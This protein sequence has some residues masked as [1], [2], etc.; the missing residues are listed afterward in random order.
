LPSVSDFDPVIE[1][2]RPP[3][4]RRL[5]IVN[6]ADLSSQP[7]TSKGIGMTALPSPE[8]YSGAISLERSP[9][10]TDLRSPA[11]A[12]EPTSFLLDQATRATRRGEHTLASSL[13]ARALEETPENLQA[14]LGL[15]S[16][17]LIQGKGQAAE[18]LALLALRIAPSSPDARLILAGLGMTQGRHEDAIQYL[19]AAK[20]DL[21]DLQ[22]RV[23]TLDAAVVA[24]LSRGLP[25]LT[26]WAGYLSAG[27][28]RN[29]LGVLSPDEGRDR[30][31]AR[32]VETR[33][34]RVADGEGFSE[35]FSTAQAIAR[36]KRSFTMVSLGA[37]YGK[38]MVN[39]VHMLRAVR[40][41]PYRLVAAE[42]DPNLGPM[43]T[44]HFRENGVGST[45]LTHI[46]AVVG[47]NNK[48]VLF[49][50]T[51]TRTGSNSALTSVD[52]IDAFVAAI[53]DGGHAERSIA[54]LLRDG[55]TGITITL[56][57][58]GVEA[59]L[60]LMSSVTLGDLLGPLDH[61]DYLDI[62]IQAAELD[63]LPPFIDLIARRVG[64][65]HLGTHGQGVHDA[66]A[67]MFRS[68][69]FR[70]EID[71]N[72]EATYETPG[73]SFRTQDGVLAV[74]NPK[75]D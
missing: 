30:R 18:E 65:I 35:W 16:S 67:G 17:Y 60:R 55:T 34:P 47:A 6:G 12:N 31:P 66:M 43:L 20:S 10:V 24:R 15:A 4:M 21:T 72:P 62:D 26:P 11:F 19:R 38:P 59:E 13:L 71:W 44:E 33:L 3:S 58:T 29:H 42:G 37:H 22:Q 45:S 46:N 61:V 27:R 41:M 64:W 5:R 51:E 74:A 73:G 40:P 36:A 57:G 8:A 75:Y 2:V 39:A 53:N 49:P 50:C 63:A 14:I 69:G 68:N 54:A 70:I 9:K 48:P 32:Y 23:Y 7:T 52:T 28:Q 56:A 1:V 25:K